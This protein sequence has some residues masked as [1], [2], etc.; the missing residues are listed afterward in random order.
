[1]SAYTSGPWYVERFGIIV[2]E[3]DGI[4]RQ[5][6]STTGDVVTHGDPSTDVVAL[7]QA[8]AALIAAAPELL[9]ALE[10]LMYGVED[11]SPLVCGNCAPSRA[12]GEVC[13][14][15]EQIN[16]RMGRARAAIRKAK[17]GVL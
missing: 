6:A 2:T 12:Q 1:M 3:I 14:H 7:Q 16:Q 13:T 8:N 4:R 11:A 10:A 15:M 17:G 9:E 5:L